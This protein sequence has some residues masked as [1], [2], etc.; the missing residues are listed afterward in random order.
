R[1]RPPARPA[2]PCGP[3]TATCRS[4]SA[5]ARPGT[6]RGRCSG[7]PEASWC[8][9][10]ARDACWRT[11]ILAPS[12]SRHALPPALRLEARLD[13]PLLQLQEQPLEEPLPLAE[14]LRG[15]HARS[16]ELAASQEPR[17]DGGREG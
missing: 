2:P 1:S 14:P 5:P 15:M 9:R 8:R 10:G 16:V 3:R 11:S 17:D 12:R 7:G 13:A 6:A 4:G